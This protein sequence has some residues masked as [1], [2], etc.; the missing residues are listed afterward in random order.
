MTSKL[1]L[2]HCLDQ[3]KELD[4]NSIDC[5]ITDPPYG[6]TACKWDHIIDPDQMWLEL[7]RVTKDNGA[8]CLFG[9]EPF[10]SL[11][12]SSNLKMYKYDWK[13]IRDKVTNFLN[14]KKQP[15]RKVELIS[16]FYKKQC[17]Y[18]PQL[19]ERDPKHIIDRS[20]NSPP[21]NRCAHWDVLPTQPST[22]NLKYPDDVLNFKRF[23]M[24]PRKTYHPSQKPVPLLEYLVKTYTN[25]GETVLDFTMGSG[26]TGVACRNLK[27]DFVG[28]ELDQE[29]FDIAKKRIEQ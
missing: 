8:I 11:L 22:T 13:W 26:S 4:D 6:T 25:E 9:M 7:K 27:R 16:V 19:T 15:M 23:D 10:S 12:R 24:D 29:F 20:G 2:G 3:L 5:V 21:K 17:T 14:A 28:I 1:L 18:N